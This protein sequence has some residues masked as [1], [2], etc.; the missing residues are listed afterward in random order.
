MKNKQITKELLD[1]IALK[2]KNGDKDTLSYIDRIIKSADWSNYN[3][4]AEIKLLKASAIGIFTMNYSKP[5][6]ILHK[7]LQSERNKEISKFVVGKIYNKLG[8]Y[9]H[10]LGN[11]LESFLA[12]SKAIDVLSEINSSDAEI[13]LANSLQNIGILYKLNNFSQFDIKNI[14]KAM[15]IY[16]KHKD[17]RGISSCY[18]LYAAY[19]QSKNNYRKSNDYLAKSLELSLKTNNDK[20]IAISYNNLASSYANLSNFKKAYELH[21]KSFL[22]RKKLKNQQL[23]AVHYMHLALT[24]H[25]DKQYQK[26]ILNNKKAEAYFEKHDYKFDLSTIYNGLYDSYLQLKKYKQAAE[27]LLKYIEIQKSMFVFDKATALHNSQLSF[28]LSIKEKEAHSLKLK[29]KEIEAINAELKQ[30]TYIT[31]HDLKEPVRSLNNY[32]QL[33]KRSL[34]N[35]LSNNQK[36]Y[37]D[38]VQLF[39]S[40]IFGLIKDLNSYTQLQEPISSDETNLNETLKSVKDSIIFYIKEKAAVLKV[41][42]LPTINAPASHMHDLFQNLIQNAIKYNKSQNPTVIIKAINHKSKHIIK[43]EDNGIGIEK[44]NLQQIFQV[45]KRLHSKSEYDGTGIGLAICKKIVEQNNGQIWA[46][47]EPGL[48]STFYI[49]FPK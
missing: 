6:T 47:S 48:G 16:K 35:E 1:S 49:S 5:I 42:D 14:A 27:Y 10:F 4:F 39:S 9:N 30:F 33:L 20:I 36:E 12:Y 2:I 24:Q 32:V 31:S 19:Y 8:I 21:Q 7:V 45:F 26:S 37:I 23:L 38:F 17:I 18:D 3:D 13:H 22:L 34:G 28:S 43:V 44:K 25:L 46:E 29:N 41:G 40:R 11:Y 15:N